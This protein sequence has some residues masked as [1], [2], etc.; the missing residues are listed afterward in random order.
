MNNRRTGAQDIDDD[1]HTAG[2][3]AG[4]HQLREQIDLYLAVIGHAR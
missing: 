3:P 2:E 1:C 4:R